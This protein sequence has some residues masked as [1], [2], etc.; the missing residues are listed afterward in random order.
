[1]I[2]VLSNS[3]KKNILN[4][5]DKTANVLVESLPLI[6][7]DLSNDVCLIGKSPECTFEEVIFFFNNKI[8]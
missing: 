5:S 2:K 6:F 7:E 4:I 8:F 1:M 3:E